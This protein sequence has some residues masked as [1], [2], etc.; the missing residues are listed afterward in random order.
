MKRSTIYLLAAIGLFFLSV[1]PSCSMYN[2]MVN[3][4]EEADSQLQDVQVQLQRR[5]DL[6]PNIVEAVKGEANFESSTLKAVTD[7]RARATQITLDPTNLK[8]ENFE[9]FQKAQSE[10]SSALSRLLVASENYP[11]LKAN[12]AFKDLRTELEGTENRIS[13]ERSKYNKKAE[14]YNK[15]VKK[16]PN[17]L[18]AKFGGFEAKKYFEADKEA[19]VAPKVKF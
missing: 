9:M 6:I 1:V 10:L 3:K 13:V 5:L 16:L 19:K 8:P 15:Y 2:E 12:Q 7:A 11:N 4:S 17:S 18:I 14:E